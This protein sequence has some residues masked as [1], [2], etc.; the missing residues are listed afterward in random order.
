MQVKWISSTFE[1]CVQLRSEIIFHENE[2][3]IGSNEIR[4]RVTLKHG[5]KTLGKKEDKRESSS[6][7]R[8]YTIQHEH[9]EHI[10]GSLRKW[11]L[12]HSRLFLGVAIRPSS[13]LFYP[14][15]RTA[16]CE[17]EEWGQPTRVI[18]RDYSVCNADALHLGLTA[19]DVGVTGIQDGHG[20]AAE[21]LT[22][23]SAEL[24]LNRG[25]KC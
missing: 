21:E 18:S 6:W 15:D 24:N 5:E 2:L 1:T 16:Q 14:L 3:A 4:V 22:A 13:F 7:S 12:C 20:R 19:E 17:Y 10:G 25:E 11:I 8:L 9:D 23:S